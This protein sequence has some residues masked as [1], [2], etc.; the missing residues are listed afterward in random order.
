VRKGDLEVCEPGKPTIAA[1]R[2]PHDI[3]NARFQRNWTIFVV[4]ISQRAQKVLEREKSRMEFSKTKHSMDIGKH[5]SN[6]RV[7]GSGLSRAAI[8]RSMLHP[9]PVNLQYSEPQRSLAI[10]LR[11]MI[12]YDRSN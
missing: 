1:E 9:S 10:V 12:D 8:C 3:T 11:I 4:A 5:R 2:S 6:R 7:F